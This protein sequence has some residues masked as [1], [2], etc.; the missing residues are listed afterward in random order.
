MPRPNNFD[1]MKAMC[2]AN[3]K[4]Q[5]APLGNILRMRKT[6]RGTEVTIGVSGD[7][8]MELM[9]GD[10]VGGLI[11]CD[12]AEFEETAQAIEVKVAPVG[13]KA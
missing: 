1:V 2:A 13:G 8:I 12:K 5:I 11:L 3:R 10:Y 4:I 7:I 6:K 9:A